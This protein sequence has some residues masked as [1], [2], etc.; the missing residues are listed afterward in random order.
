M[1]FA[2]TKIANQQH[3]ISKGL[4]KEAIGNTIVANA[5]YAGQQQRLA[6]AMGMSPLAS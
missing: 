3:A 6:M 4:T 2:P 5:D 1:D